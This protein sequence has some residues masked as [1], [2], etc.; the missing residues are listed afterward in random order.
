M[1]KQ[2]NKCN[3]KVVFAG[4]TGVGKSSIVGRLNNHSI[5]AISTTIGAIYSQ[6]SYD[7][8]KI[9]L[10]LWDTAGHERYRSMTAAYFRRAQYCILVFDVGNKQSFEELISWK[11]SCDNSNINENSVLYILIGNKIDKQKVVSDSEIKNLCDIFNVNSYHETSAFTGEG[12]MDFRDSLIKDVCENNNFDVK[13]VLSINNP[14]DH[15]RCN[16]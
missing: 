13:K 11:T 10:D 8:K 4:R 7:N 2:G 15:S 1:L 12:I 16:C 3:V 14:S 5:E 6:L 9:N